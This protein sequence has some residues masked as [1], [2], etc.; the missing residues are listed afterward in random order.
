MRLFRQETKGI[1]VIT[2]ALMLTLI[3]VTAATKFAIFTS[4][5]QK[6]IQDTET[7]NIHNKEYL[8]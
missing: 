1:P 8:I 5:K 3:V 7:Y 4:Q 2:G 6:E